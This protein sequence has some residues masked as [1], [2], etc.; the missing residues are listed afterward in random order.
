MKE[1]V[2]RL[3]FDFIPT[4]DQ[5]WNATKYIHSIRGATFPS[6]DASDFHQCVAFT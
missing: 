5:W 4:N 6:N 1:Y 2:D 3:T